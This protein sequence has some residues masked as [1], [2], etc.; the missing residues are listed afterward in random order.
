[1]VE[2]GSVDCL[3][4]F[5]PRKMGMVF[6]LGFSNKFRLDFRIQQENQREKAHQDQS[7][8]KSEV[9]MCHNQSFFNL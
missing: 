6:W 5:R 7:E 9:L 1:L 2:L 3:E 4:E 8:I